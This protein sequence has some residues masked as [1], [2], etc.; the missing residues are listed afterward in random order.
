MNV[1]RAAAVTAILL[2]A[3]GCGPSRDYLA[4]GDR[5]SSANKYP[6]AAILYRKAI[7][8]DPRSAEAYYKLGLV[9]R[10][11]TNY[12][13]AY[14]SFFRAVMLNPEFDKAQIELGNLYLGD[15]LIASN[16]NP[17]VHQKISQIA[18]RLLAKDPR[19]FA[20]LRF[21]GY[22]ALSDRKPEEAVT[23]FRQA[24]EIDPAQA[25]VLLG[26]TQSLLL[27]GRYPEARQTGADLI[28]RNKTFGSVYDVLYAYEMSAGHAGDAESLLKLKITNNPQDR[29]CV[30]QLAEHYWRTSQKKQAFQ[31]LDAML[32][33][34]KI[35]WRAY[36]SA[37]YFYRRL[38][39]WDRA[40]E[41]LELGLRAHPEESVAFASSKADVL[42]LA[43]KPQEAIG[44]LSDTISHHPEA[45]E[46]RK[47]RAVLLLDS[48]ESAD[49]ALAMREMQSVTQ[50][51]AED[52]VAAF[53]LGQAYAS[54]GLLV[55]ASQQMDLVARKEPRNVPARLALAE[56]SSR[57]KEFQKSLEYSEQVLA[58]EP[59]LQNARLLHA[60]ALVGLGLLDRARAEYNSLIRDQPSYTEAKLQ[61]AMLNVMQKRFP[62]AEK[63]FGELYHPNTGDYRALK[64]IVELY[65]AQDKVEKALAVIS[66]ELAHFPASIAI[67][68]LLASTALRA[69][70]FD[71]AVQ[72]YEQVVAWGQDDQDACTALGQLYQRKLDK[73]RSLAMFQ[74]ALDLAP[75]DWRAVFRLAAAQQEFG[76]QSQAR[77]N[78][79]RA[80][81]LG[82]SDPDLLNN[83]A[84]LE[85]D[86]GS[87]LDDA[88]T[89]AQSALSRSP[90]NAQ[91]ADTIGF[92]YLKKGDAAS[93]QQIF[94]S[95]CNRYP[96][97]SGFRYHLALALLQNGNRQQGESELRAAIAANPSLADQEHVK[98]LL[99][100]N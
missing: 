18:D 42:K 8:K 100:R 30:V 98:N 76:L 64:G 67:R 37:G 80:I 49:K 59:G 40:I 54:N 89:L 66:G 23:F 75:N 97:E 10:A 43:G 15:Y 90:G 71:L 79:R 39:E 26:L 44:L 31:L 28:D 51:S 88:M 47:A 53:L 72:Q 63:K 6:E 3:I 92:I 7:Q 9:Q 84:F 56:F 60:T 32:R 20:G 19:S 35:A 70:R 16:R 5:L 46:L 99:G 96:K 25:D 22:L 86:M 27:V 52:M 87:D 74:K 73:T 45:T 93:A 33:E 14:D 34:E 82:G 55:K 24:R 62:E 41:T 78:Y 36:A 61:L 95:L 21:R 38:G 48:N 91:Y 29:D 4:E 50:A 1:R 58:L 17:L 12:A 11:N 13:A 81:E 57:A 2:T 65:M 94:Q 83:L 85:A 77:S 68:G 69:G